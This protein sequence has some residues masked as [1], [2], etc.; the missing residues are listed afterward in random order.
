MIRKATI[1]DTT[2]I[3]EIYN[4]AVDAKFQTGFT[5]RFEDTAVTDMIVAHTDAYPIF[6]Y[7]SDGRIAGWASISAYRP[8]RDAFR[9][10]AEVSYF[11]HHDYQRKGIGSALL[12]HAM[13]ACQNLGYKTLIAIILDKNAGSIK[14]A[15]KHGFE[16]WAFL[17][18]V[19]DFGGEECNHVYY[20]KKL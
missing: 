6:V 9:Y 15:Q 13:D 3:A 11:M 17:P 4:Q 5:K 2:G 14:L 8:N 20:G 12:L 10:T 7:V 18:G 1:D 16:Q 19:A